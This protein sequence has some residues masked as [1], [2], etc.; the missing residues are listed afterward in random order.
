VTL[1]RRSKSNLNFCCNDGG[2]CL[3][4]VEFPL[5]SSKAQAGLFLLFLGGVFGADV[6]PFKIKEK[7]TKKLAC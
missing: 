1:L 5:D 7:N 6:L 4:E 3:A 2:D